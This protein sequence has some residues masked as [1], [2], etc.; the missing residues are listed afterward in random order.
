MRRSYLRLAVVLPIVVGCHQT[1]PQAPESKIAP[2]DAGDSKPMD[3]LDALSEQ[4]PN[5]GPDAAQLLARPA[6]VT[7]SLHPV[8][9]ATR[10]DEDWFLVK[11]ERVPADAQ[12]TISGFE[13]GRLV[14]E[15]YDRDRDKILALSTQP[16]HALAMPTVRVRDAM[17]I[18][19]SSP[20]GGSGPYQLALRLSEPDPNAEA[21]PNDRP[22]DATPLALDQVMHATLGT[23]Q[24]QDWYRVELNPNAGHGPTD[25]GVAVLVPGAVQGGAIPAQDGRGGD[26]A[27]TPAAPVPPATG[28]GGRGPGS[29]LGSAGVAGS[30]SEQVAAAA[31]L[32]A[33]DAL[34][35]VSVSAIPGVRT[36]L[37]IFD[38]NQAPVATLRASKVGA[39]IEERD[40]ALR[41]ETTAVYLVVTGGPHDPR[42]PE[43]AAYQIAVH[44]EP[45][46]ADFEVEP[47]DLP[48][49]ATPITTHRAG[50]LSPAGD[51]DYYLLHLGGASVI[52]AV[53][54]PLDHV[55]S[56]L[57]VVDEENGKDHVLVRINEGGV[58][59]PEVIPALVLPAGD[60]LIRVQAAAHQVGDKW[61]RDQ[62][63][64]DDPYS[65]TLSVSPDQGNV[66]REPNDK[67][68]Q[69]TPLKIGQ[70]LSGYAY[71]PKDIDIFQLDLS[72]Q[73]VAA[74]VIIR[75]AGA[76][77][78]P[79][80]L[81]LHGAPQGAK[82]GTLLNTSDLGKPGA[83]EEIRAKLDPGIYQIVVRPRPTSRA[84][85]QPLADPDS[86]YQ[87][88]VQSE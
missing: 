69:A 31:P 24:D 25:A 6:R 22:A 79:L 35:R 47:N 12:V 3:G 46:P 86:P 7:A 15:L 85:G 60:H 4:E 20:S 51:V 5:D 38:Q 80:A 88:S 32:E 50:Y 30:S 83:S 17:L 61:V 10:P 29:G 82:L 43:P 67:P 78:V 28:S 55:D 56:E 36:Q 42:G 58:K 72:A 54:S 57:A 40:L 75:L 59:E 9:P 2:V 18:R 77:R 53:L 66:E 74:G 48:A 23:A 64:A 13:G 39:E 33:P 8:Q 81:E 1:P 14:V 73:P 68:D 34:L 63:N 62:A 44:R 49:Q 16:G 65:L 87:L 70:T 45:A 26:A 11:P 76:L 21:E 37:A 52:H 19:L 71:P 27:T 84:P 41:A